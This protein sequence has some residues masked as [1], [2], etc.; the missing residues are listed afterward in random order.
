M[1]SLAHQKKKNEKATKEEKEM[2]NVLLLCGTGAS[3]GFMARKTS[4]A[5]KERGIELNIRARS[6]TELLDYI[7]ETDLV[8]VGPH[9]K[10]MLK[11]IE[12][13]TKEYQI[14]VRLIEKETYGNLDGE[15]L[16]N[17]IIKVLN[18]GE[19]V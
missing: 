9:F 15:E 4:Q 12:S 5:A 3:S 7:D 10:H 8:L 19:T 6:E 13:T 11:S 1:L 17:T 14:P 2:K 18:L 16:L